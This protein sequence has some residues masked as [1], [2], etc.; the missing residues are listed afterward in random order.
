MTRQQEALIEVAP[1]GCVLASLS[2][3]GRSRAGLNGRIAITSQT[4]TSVAT[5]LADKLQKYKDV[6]GILPRG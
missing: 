6:A 1:Q 3:H 5:C 2:E 4:A